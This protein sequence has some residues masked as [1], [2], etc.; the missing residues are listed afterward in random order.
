M[1]KFDLTYILYPYPL[2]VK[3]LYQSSSFWTSVLF[4]LSNPQAQTVQKPPRE[5]KKKQSD[6]LKNNFRRSTLA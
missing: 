6:Y 3:P 4:E 1:A 2:F 5:F